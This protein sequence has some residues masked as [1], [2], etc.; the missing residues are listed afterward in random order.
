MPLKIIRND[1]T[2]VCADAIVNTANPLP[3]VGRGTDS[4]IYAAAGARQLLA[5]REQ[6]GPIPPGCAAFTPAFDLH[7]RYIIHAVSPRWIDG[8]HG[9]E[10]LLRRAYDAA[11]ALSDVLRCKSVAFPLMSA[12]SYGFPKAVALAVAIRAFTDYLIDHEDRT[13][14]LVLFNSEAFGLASNLF[15]DLK[16]YIDDR[17]VALHSRWDAPED[18]S[19]GAPMLSM[20]GSDAAA[21]PPAPCMSPAPAENARAVRPGR[22]TSAKRPVRPPAQAAR[23]DR[24]AAPAPAERA[25]AFAALPSGG[26]LE[27]LLSRSGPT[28]SEYLLGLLQ[29]RGGKDSEVYK[30]AEVSKQLFSKILSTRC[31]QPTKSTAIQLAIG[32]ELDLPGTQQLLEKAGYA[33]T[34]SSKADLVVQYF[35]ERRVYSVPFINEAL[36]DCGLPLLKTGLKS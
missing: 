3:V 10:A 7:A 2:L 12:G 4:A 1:I 35:I 31:Y 8:R 21:E 34:R 16:S 27:E 26:S 33:L 28:F 30:R 24:E 5:A 17:Y 14:F 32:L 36:Y 6:L 18:A 19:V 29:E 23:A 25:D 13:V 9:E 20:F 15:D 22:K 11:L